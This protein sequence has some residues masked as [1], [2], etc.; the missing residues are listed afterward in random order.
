MSAVGSSFL[1]GCGLLARIFNITKPIPPCSTAPTIA[2]EQSPDLTIDV[3]AHFFN[4]TDLQVRE[5]IQKNVD[6]HFPKVLKDLAAAIVGDLSWDAAPTGVEEFKQLEVFAKCQENLDD[7]RE[8]AKVDGLTALTKTA[9]FRQYAALPETAKNSSRALYGSPAVT[10][11]TL[12]TRFG[13]FVT[14]KLSALHPAAALPQDM[15][16]SARAAGNI[17]ASDALMAVDR[18]VE[19]IVQGFQYRFVNIQDYSSAGEVSPAIPAPATKRT[20]DL[21]IANL[22]D[23]DWPLAQ[24]HPTPTPIREQLK[25]MEEISIIKHGH[26]HAFIPYCPMRQVAM[27]AKKRGNEGSDIPLEEMKHFIETRGFIGFKLYPPMGFKP[28][29]NADVD[30][31]VWVKNG[32]PDW[33]NDKVRYPE[34]GSVASF[35]QRLDDELNA[36]Y[37]WAADNGVPITGHAEPTNGPSKVFESFDL[38]DSWAAALK[39]HPDLRIN[40]GHTGGISGGITAD[41]DA[42]TVPENSS[43]LLRL[44]AN[45]RNSTGENAYGDLSYSDGLLKNQDAFESLLSSAI[46]DVPLTADRLMYGTDWFMT[47]QESGVANY[48]SKFEAVLADLDNQHKDLPGPPLSQRIFALNAA[49]FLGLFPGDKTRVRLEKFYK[50]KKFDLVNNPPDWMKKVKVLRRS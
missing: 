27:K 19:F 8:K 32:L 21:I 47:I 18:Y 4:G 44:F 25:V 41:S 22:V 10:P 15:M 37:R 13:D 50:S 49:T 45:G 33:M 31:S 16:A 42:H 29:G 1:S 35:G 34:D 40:F 39:A 24:G 20:L 36:L 30:Q 6:V 9:T 14:A 28:M 12:H 43:A 17:K 38:A 26:V 46:Q 48:L 2:T 11:D 3:H 7:A 23:Y 5:F